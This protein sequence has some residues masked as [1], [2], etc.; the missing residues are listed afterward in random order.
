[1]QNLLVLF[2]LVTWGGGAQEYL[3]TGGVL[4][5]P[6]ANLAAKI[7][8]YLETVPSSV[9]L[10]CNY[11]QKIHFSFSLRFYKH[12]CLTPHWQNL[13]LRI[14]SKGRFL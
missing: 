2:N 11:D 14:L 6:S 13:K 10:K 9:P 5:G 4:L 8:E 1:M 7:E 3:L 12:V